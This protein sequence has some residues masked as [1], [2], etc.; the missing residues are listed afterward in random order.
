MSNKIEFKIETNLGNC[1]KLWHEFSP[2]LCIYDDWD[3]RY[4]FAKYF[5]YPL[6]FLVGSLEG[7]VI[8]VLPLEF[9]STNNYYEFFGGLSMEYNKAF[10]KSG[11]E[12][13][14]PQFYKN[15]PKSVRLE[16][17]I[18]VEEILE[19]LDFDIETYFLNL[20]KFKNFDDFLYLHFDKKRRK[21][22]KGIL[23]KNIN[24]KSE[25]FFNEI[26][27]LE[28]LF[29]LN[30]KRFDNEEDKSSFFEQHE[31]EIFKDILKL[32]IPHEILSIK[33]NNQTQAVSLSC[34]YN[35]CYY[36]LATAANVWDYSDLGTYLNLMN[37]KRAIEKNCEI[38]DFGYHDCNWKKLWHLT[39]NNLYKYKRV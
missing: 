11:Y 38:I 5:E 39:S 7:K 35:G 27:D 24:L 3:F 34:F 31:E 17:M 32:D 19:I 29:S 28:I 37:V 10:V 13:Y 8:G 14:I 33:I 22:F 20:E 16:N 30:K 26:Q 4:C 9:D 21:N 1:R 36:C 23:K 15:L 18:G 2:N 6:H 12:K 25:I